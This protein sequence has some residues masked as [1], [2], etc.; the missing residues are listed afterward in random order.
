[1]Q[2]ICDKEQ[3][4]QIQKT[5]E[6][7]FRKRIKES[8]MRMSEAKLLIF[9]L[10]LSMDEPMSAQEIV[11]RIT[12]VHYVS[13]YRTLDALRKAGVV[14]QVPRG[15]KILFELSDLFNP[16][17]HHISCE[18]CGRLSGINDKEIEA[19]IEKISLESGYKS[20]KHHLELYG[21]C[22]KCRAQ[23]KT[24]EQRQRKSSNG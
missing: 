4:V 7:E 16:H 13:I 8:G 9:E 3:L 17:H 10:L 24:T 5:T 14:V 1:M 19:L 18:E 2:I 21:L 11:Q 22:E 12:H 23:S 6:A 20:T 15:F